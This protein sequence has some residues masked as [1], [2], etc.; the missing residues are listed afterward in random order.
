V[1]QTPLP[2]GGGQ[3]IQLTRSLHCRTTVEIRHPRMGFPLLPQPSAA[4]ALVVINL[5]THHDPQPDTQFAC[6]CDPCLAHSFLDELATLE[7]LQL[8]VFPY[9]MHPCFGP[10]IA[11]QGVALLGQFSQSLSLPAGVLTPNHPEVAGHLVGG[12]EATRVT[13]KN[14]GRQSRHRTYARM[15]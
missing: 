7:A 13:E 10:Q 12:V 4:T 3:P 9:R 1:V 2:W 11:Q 8:R 5:V 14:I 15:G 6:R